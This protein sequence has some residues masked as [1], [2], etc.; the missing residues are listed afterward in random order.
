MW[1]GTPPVSET[2]AVP[3]AQSPNSWVS[4]FDATTGLHIISF[5]P[6]INSS[7]SGLWAIQDDGNGCLW[8]GGA[9]ISTNNVTQYAMTRLC[10][11]SSFDFV[12]PSTPGAAQVTNIG[13]DSVDL[14]WG[15]STDAVGVEGYRI[16][17][18]TTNAV[19][20]DALTESGTIIELAPG[21]YT[22]YVK[23]YDAA[24][25]ISWRSGFTTFTVTGIPVDTERPSTPGS[26]SIVSNV[27]GTVVLDWTPSTDNIGVAG[28][29][30]YDSATN[31][32]VS[33]SATASLT[34]TGLA[35]GTYSYYLK[36]FDA[37]GNTSWKSGNRSVTVVNTPAP[38]IEA[39]TAPSDLTAIT[40][41][42]DS[43]DL[44][45]LASTDN[46]AVAGYQIVDPLTDTVLL[47]VVSVSGTIT[48][49]AP[50]SYDFVVRAYDA[51]GNVSVASAVLTVV[52]V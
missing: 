24:G 6:D 50:G 7:G 1:A 2:N 3:F 9:L 35:D 45:W 12:R 15:A 16:Y 43:V 13:V 37:A 10:D 26:P 49:L 8:L 42:V 40:I 38:D 48:G 17:D 44:E 46:V 20:L 41:G 18:S 27:N 32:V 30:L 11:T 14:V 4:A 28:Y 33:T 52:I 34:L 51:A 19:L 5:R 47:D 31:A 39:P 22:V 36:A 23:A 21:T 25:N 29:T